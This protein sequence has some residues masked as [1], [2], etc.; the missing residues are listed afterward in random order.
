[1][2]KLR[3]VSE[4]SFEEIRNVK[5][6]Y[7]RNNTRTIDIAKSFQIIP[8]SL[9]SRINRKKWHLVK[10]RYLHY[11]VFLSAHYNMS[12]RKM[13]KIAK[14]NY[15]GLCRARR[16]SGIIVDFD[17][18]PPNK[19]ITDA[20]KQK[21][22]DLYLKGMSTYSV[23]KMTG[24]KT[25]KTVS[26]VLKEKEIDRRTSSDYTHYNREYF[27][28]IDCH[29]KAYIIGLLLTDGY[30]LRDY[31][32]IGIQ[33]TEKDRYLLENIAKLLGES[34]SVSGIKG[35]GWR[36][37]CDRRVFCKPMKRLVCYCP[38][39]AEDLKKLGVVK[40]KT[41]KLNKLPDI[42]TKYL[43]SFFRGLLDGDG[44]IGINKSNNYPWCKL[45]SSN[46]RFLKNCSKLLKELG[47]KNTYYK[48][49]QNGTIDCVYIDGGRNSIQRFV[50]WIYNN[51]EDLYLRR[52]YERAESIIDQKNG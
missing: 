28:N 51:K 10:N 35:K 38:Q 47:F 29:S 12:L 36:V 49:K 44:T 1:M 9:G 18:S 43:S 45:M 37:I 16:E 26:D 8:G 48:K 7:C 20:T 27:N 2:L 19:I 39:I 4:L 40:R 46:S 32:G 30:V 5:R 42:P 15:S 23:A 33:L 17:R 41:K 6:L 34:C 14:I 3:K 52:K 25:A 31:D 22:V 21:M 13:A 24:F 50:E 11:I